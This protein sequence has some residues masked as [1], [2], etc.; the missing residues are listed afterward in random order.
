[1]AEET[2]DRDSRGESFALKSSDKQQENVSVKSDD[3]GSD[4]SPVGTTLPGKVVKTGFLSKKAR[5]KF[6]RPWTLRNI[7]LD[8]HCRLFYYDRDVLKG[9]VSLLGTGVRRL[10]PAAADGRPF[11][12]EIVNIN[13]L[14]SSRNKCSSLVLAAGSQREADEWIEAI[15]S[16]T[17]LA[18][19]TNQTTEYQTFAVSSVFCAYCCPSNSHC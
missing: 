2:E 14:K 7:I 5:A 4:L 15:H 6:I 12:F 10:D 17:R 9:V 11:A 13:D 1:M 16:M 3:F 19:R 18:N 8:E